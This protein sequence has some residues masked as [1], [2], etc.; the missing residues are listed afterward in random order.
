MSVVGEKSNHEIQR[1]V[2]ESH[3]PKNGMYYSARVTCYYVY[4]NEQMFGR[5]SYVVSLREFMDNVL[6]IHD[7]FIC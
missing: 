4:T 3:K 6:V 2:N 1:A 7:I 5:V